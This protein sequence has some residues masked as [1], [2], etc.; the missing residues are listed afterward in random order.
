MSQELQSEA[1]V[2][3][4]LSGPLHGTANDT[5]FFHLFIYVWGYLVSSLLAVM[6][7]ETSRIL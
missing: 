5:A 1:A 4:A 7:D 3:H 6:E 2:C